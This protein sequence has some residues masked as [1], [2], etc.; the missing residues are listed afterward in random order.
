METEGNK[1]VHTIIGDGK[2]D[3]L[4][5]P[6]GVSR[7]NVDQSYRGIDLLLQKVIRQSD[8]KAWEEIEAK[9]NYTYEKLDWALS[10]LEK[11]TAFLAVIK[12]RLEKGEKLLFKPNLVSAEGYEPYTAGQALGYT[13]LTNWSFVAAVMRWFHDRAGISFYQMCVGEA[14]TVMSS[15]AAS[16]CFLKP[17]GRAVTT[18]A[19]IEGRSDD[20]YGGWGF[21]FVRKYLAQV[22]DPSRG[23]DPMKGFEESQAGTYI[24]PGQVKDKLMVYDLNRICDDISK[25]R[26][27]PVPK[28]ENFQSII[29]H[30]VICGG[31][32]DN[33]TD[34]ERYPGSIIVNLPKLKVHSQAFFTNAIKN[35]GIGLYPMEVSRSDSCNWEYATPPI[36]IPA[37]KG[38][39]PH[40]VWIP[41]LDPITC[42]P[43]KNPDGTYKVTRT[44]GLT[45]TM[46]DILDALK[47]QDLLMLNIV[48]AIEVTNHDHT[49]GGLGILE[50]EGLIVVGLDPVAIDLFCSRYMFS[51]VGL[52]EA[53]E[54]GLDDG[55]GGRFPQS[56][57]V[58]T[59][60]NGTIVT[61]SGYDCP[62]SRDACNKRAEKRG[63]GKRSYYVLGKDDQT[64]L[65]LGSFK[66]RLG[67]VDGDKFKEIVTSTFFTDTQKMPWDMQT[68]FLA[69]L[70]AVDQL[71]GA[72][73]SKNFLEAFDEDG[74]GVVSYE[75][76]RKK[77]LFGTTMFLG[78][79]RSSLR[80]VEDE[81][82]NIRAAYALLATSLRCSNPEWN[83]QG[84][85][86]TREQ[87]Y[88]AV[89][90]TAQLMSFSSEEHEDPFVPGLLFGKGKWPG[91]SLAYDKLIKQQLYGFKYPLRV[92]INCLYGLA[93]TYADFKQN[94]RQFMGRLRGAPD[95]KGPQKYVESVREGRMKPMDFTF[96]VPP[97]FGADLPNVE[98][99]SD[100][101]KIMAVWF[102]RGRVKWP[103]MRY[104]D[105][106]PQN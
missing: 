80:A 68:T 86:F 5:S 63:L 94:D 89:C 19:V 10:A 33:A 27:I 18:E 67:I 35:L 78:G 45:G 106:E 40:Q 65:P 7:L 39:I 15:V 22:S 75:E 92:G 62:L 82:E 70:S 26:E 54:A 100:P 32:R 97:G 25:G 16:Y 101:E 69:Y 76:Y 102:E 71:E 31:D 55:A 29:L 85:D 34:R 12:Q 11:E 56:V 77:G 20:F 51:N 48:D 53:E 60:Q 84:H 36:K 21:Y 52:K 91:F 42:L 28:G 24:P 59:L 79:L 83:P 1:T 44:G 58:P 88:G 8:E 87:Q 50:P 23:D 47:G 38:A 61:S 98:E 2:L 64:G 30:K 104:Q 103:D 6:L 13:A 57:P 46:L 105:I 14:A 74:D 9:I 81:S 49:G 72:S 37:V 4:G 95:T 96:Y 66:G 99:S 3:H 93:C 43:T 41:E 90:R 73:Y 17:S